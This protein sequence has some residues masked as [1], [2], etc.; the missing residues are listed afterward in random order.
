MGVLKRSFL[1]SLEALKVQSWIKPQ[2]RLDVEVEWGMVGKADK[3]GGE[4]H[5]ESVFAVSPSVCERGD[6]E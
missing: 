4:R 3:R 6:H 5:S 2:S 1:W